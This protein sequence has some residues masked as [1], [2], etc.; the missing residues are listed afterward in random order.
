MWWAEEVGVYQ[1]VCSRG[2]VAVV[3]HRVTEPAPMVVGV[4]AYLMPFGDNPF[5]KLRMPLDVLTYHEE[6]CLGVELPQGVENE[7]C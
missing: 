3:A 2:V 1:L 4:I 6:G 5:V 7:G